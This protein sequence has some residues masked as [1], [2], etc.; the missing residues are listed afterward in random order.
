MKSPP[1]P[2]KSLGQCFLTDRQYAREIV[3]ALQIRQGDTVVEVGPGRGFLTELLVDTPAKIIGIEIDNRLQEFLSD[4]FKPAANFSLVHSDFMNY[5]L[6]ALAGIPNLKVVGNLPYHLSSGI[7]Y[8]L[9]EHNRAARNDSSL[10]WF[11]LG[12]LM[13]QREVAERMVAKEGTRVYGKLS[14]FVQA[15]A[16]VDLHSIVPAA[17]FRP[18]PQVDGGVVR[19]EF[20]KLPEHYPSDYQLFERVIRFTFSQRR[21]MLKSTL[22][23]LAGVHPMWQSIEFDFTR[24]PES[25]GVGEWCTLISNIAARIDKPRS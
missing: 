2:K 3:A 13:M 16:V 10:P 1:L 9:L 25:L 22:S 12:V 8:K 14:I 24:R 7:I 4:K 21:K 11:T 19:M 5:D 6:S 15:E 18:M 17:A 23:Q 20:L